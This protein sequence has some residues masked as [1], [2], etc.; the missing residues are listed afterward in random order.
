MKRA[1][2]FNPFIQT[3]LGGGGLYVLVAMMWLVPDRRIET[4]YSDKA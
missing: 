1:G 4:A 3:L 2:W